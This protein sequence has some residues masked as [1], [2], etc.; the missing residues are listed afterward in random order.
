MNDNLSVGSLYPPNEHTGVAFH[1][2]HSQ[3]VLRIT[4]DGRLEKG[5]GYS[6]EEAAQVLFDA[7]SNHIA[8][9]WKQTRDENAALLEA[10]KNIAMLTA[11]GDAERA[12]WVALGILNDPRASIDVARKEVQP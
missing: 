8:G 10:V 2:S 3:T 12:N 9:V 7:V 1:G 5:P 6:T 4:S 11:N